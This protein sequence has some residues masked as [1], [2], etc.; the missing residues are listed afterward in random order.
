MDRKTEKKFAKQEAKLERKEAKHEGA[1]PPVE[2]GQTPANAG[3]SR[4]ATTGCDESLWN[5]VYNPTRLQKLSPCIA[6]TGTVSESVAD[7]DGDQ[8]FLL[9]VDPGQEAL[10]NERNAKK[11]TGSLV[12][13]I[14]CANPVKLKKVKSVCAG[15]KNPIAIPQ[16][17]TRVRAIGTFVIDSHNGWTEIHPVTRLQRI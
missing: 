5:R 3:I 10:V 6:A 9:K 1:N 13:E 2:G 7:D 11:K 4:F 17:G 14:V 8:H 15:Y 16:N 12:V